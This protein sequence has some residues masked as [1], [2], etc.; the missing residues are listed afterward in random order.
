MEDVSDK[1][2]GYIP[3]LREEPV[4]IKEPEDPTLR[5][6]QENWN[7][8]FSTW[9]NENAAE[10]TTGVAVVNSNVEDEKRGTR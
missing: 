10:E 6:R 5:G 3:C 9:N 1:P 2:V 8:Q 4:L 7:N